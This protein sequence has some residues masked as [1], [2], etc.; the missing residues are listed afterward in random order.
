MNYFDD[1]NTSIGRMR[2]ASTLQTLSNLL[3]K[4]PSAQASRNQRI[5][6]A[7]KAI[8]KKRIQL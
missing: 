3:T 5:T 2:Y 1:T 4:H 8:S 6:P 7:L